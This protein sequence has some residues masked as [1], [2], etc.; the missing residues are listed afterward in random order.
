MTRHAVGKNI[1]GIQ[2]LS[3]M[4]SV[5]PRGKS[6]ILKWL[7]WGGRGLPRK[8]GLETDGL[9]SRK[10]EQSMKGLNEFSK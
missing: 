1:A 9:D 8:V 5:H 2:D 3:A 6:T 4:Y 10:K 7:K